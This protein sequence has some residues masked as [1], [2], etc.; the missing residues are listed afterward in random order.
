LPVRGVGELAGA[1]P[2][3][4]Q[5][6]LV[7]PGG[8]KSAMDRDGRFTPEDLE[9]C[10]ELREFLD[11]LLADYDYR[12]RSGEAYQPPGCVWRGFPDGWQ[13]IPEAEVAAAMATLDDELGTLGG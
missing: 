6:M 11:A 9:N 1:G 12:C 10:P 8:S 4:D 13:R 5:Q 3:L 7:T 2:V